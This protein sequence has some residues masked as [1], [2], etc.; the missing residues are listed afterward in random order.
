MRTYAV[1]YN[2]YLGAWAV[3]FKDA[4]EQEWYIYQFVASQ[5]IAESITNALNAKEA[6]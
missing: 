5:D 6:Q 4:G 3:I 1:L 2:A